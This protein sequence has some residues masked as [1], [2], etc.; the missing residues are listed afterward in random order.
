[1]VFKRGMMG[2]SREP[3]GDLSD[4]EEEREAKVAAF[5]FSNSM[6]MSLCFVCFRTCLLKTA[7]TGTYKSPK[8]RRKGQFRDIIL[9]FSQEVFIGQ[10]TGRPWA[11]THTRVI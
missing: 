3:L 9:C 2:V 1:M 5:L 6:P 10:A 8:A 7:R 4:W 11:H